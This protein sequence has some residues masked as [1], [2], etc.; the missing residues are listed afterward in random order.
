MTTLLNHSPLGASS[1]ERWMN[2]SGSVPLMA[3]AGKREDSEFAKLGTAAHDFGAKALIGG[4]DAWEFVGDKYVGSDGQEIECDQPMADAIQVYLDHCR[5]L[6]EAASRTWIE[7][8]MHAPQIHHN[9]YGTVD[10]AAL[11]G[12]TLHIVDYKHGEGI[13]VDAER[14]LQLMYYSAMVLYTAGGDCNP[15]TVVMTIVQPRAFHPDGPIRTFTTTARE[16]VLWVRDELR[17]RMQELDDLKTPE[18]VTGDHC[19]WCDKLRCPKLTS[20][21][22]ALAPVAA[23]DLLVPSLS[24]DELGEY[25]RKWQIIKGFGRVIED[26]IYVRRMR[27]NEVPHSKLVQKKSD[28]VFKDGASEIFINEFGDDA[29]SPKKLKSPAEM[30]KLG[31]KAKALVS[32]YAFSPNT[33]LTVAPLED[34]RSS[35][36]ITGIAE[37]YAHLLAAE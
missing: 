10:F 29:Y 3:S 21:Y 12:D 5:P 22:Q 8:K 9:C 37:Q 30:A 7:G 14:N 32:E 13:A 15:E 25:Y 36:K 16:I 35:V 23:G 27:G 34:K 1:A 31:S 18:Y 28:R 19:R 6:K 20:D 2:C 33:G 26:E 4:Q 11:C 24:D 17:T